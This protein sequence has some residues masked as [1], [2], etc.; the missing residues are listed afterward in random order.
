MDELTD[1]QKAV[2]DFERKWWKYQGA[3]E[4]AMM[5]DLGLKPVRFYQILGA[6]IDNPAALAY[7]P[8]GVNRM[9][10]LRDARRDERA[11]R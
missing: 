10:R 4:A 1:E 7:D 8:V 2:L 5:Y 11:A 3:K 9:R 6:L